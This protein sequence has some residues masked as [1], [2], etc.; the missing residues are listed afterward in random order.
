MFE[1]RRLRLG[2]ALWLAA[3]PGVVVISLTVIPQVLATVPHRVPLGLAV[4]A[5]MLQSGVLVALAVWAGVALSRSLGLGAPVFEA[6]LSGT[7]AWPALRPQLI[8]AAIVG[9]LAGGMLVLLGRIAP[10]ELLA[11]GQTY[12]IPLAAKLLY[13]G[14]TEEMLMRWGL[15]T[16]LVW[17]PWSFIQKRRGLP[18]P[19]YVIGAIFIAALLFGAF[20]LP[21]AAAM[22][23]SLTAPV[24]TY[25]IVGNTVP[26]VLFGFLYWRNGLEA[27]ILAHALAHAAAVLVGS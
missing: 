19:A 24:V 17:L 5:S 6:A 1:N 9:L 26:A 11:L 13:G 10:T 21:A 22:G 3:M 8:P 23:A 16:A 15:M 7:G 4:A 14:V 18:R 25:V 27:A 2:V 12:D 20:H